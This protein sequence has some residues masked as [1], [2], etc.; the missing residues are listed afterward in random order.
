MKIFFEN[1]ADD[2]QVETELPL[3]GSLSQAIEIFHNLPDY[4]GSYIGLVNRDGNTVQISKYDRFL[5]LIEIPVYQEQASYYALFTYFQ[6]IQ[7]LQ[8]LYKGFDPYT[9]KGLKFEQYLNKKATK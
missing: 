1:Y 4:D 7:L 5:F 3:E 6:V 2:L 9:I 8:D